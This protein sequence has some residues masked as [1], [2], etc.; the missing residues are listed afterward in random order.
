M[1]AEYKLESLL[2][3][4]S[5]YKLSRYEVF[6]K[7]VKQKRLQERMRRIEMLRTEI[8]ELEKAADAGSVSSRQQ[9]PGKYNSLAWE[10]LFLKEGKEAEQWIKKGLA[11]DP[12]NKY[13]IGNMPH[14]LLLQGN[15]QARSE[16]SSLAEKYF[17][18]LDYKTYK[19]AFLGDFRQFKAEEVAI[20]GMDEMI[21]LLGGSI[22]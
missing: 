9:L 2:D 20:P 5:Q 8:Q 1:F 19:D 13:L 15:E 3:L 21:I 17:G 6:R 4:N 16:Y 12:E 14:A 22:E 7:V 18:A 10:L 11:I